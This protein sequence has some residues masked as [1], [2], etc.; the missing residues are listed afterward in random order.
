[1]KKNVKLAK[2]ILMIFQAALFFAV[3][4]IADVISTGVYQPDSLLRHL[5][6]SMAAGIFFSYGLFWL[7]PYLNKKFPAKQNNSD[8]SEAS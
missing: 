6:T 1:M 5:L 8:H 2:F 3:F 4:A 7:I